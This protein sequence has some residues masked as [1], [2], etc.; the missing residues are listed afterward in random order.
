MVHLVPANN[1][2]LTNYEQKQ[3]VEGLVHHPNGPSLS[4]DDAQTF[5]RN[6]AMDIG[7]RNAIA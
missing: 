4:F 5:A 7:K 1:P 2:P 6:R 3:I